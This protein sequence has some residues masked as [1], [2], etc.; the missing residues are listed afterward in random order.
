[1]YYIYVQKCI[2]INTHYLYDQT[3]IYNLYNFLMQK[4]SLISW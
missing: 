1:M 2:A 3:V 4:S